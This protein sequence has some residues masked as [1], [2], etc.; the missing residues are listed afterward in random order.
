MILSP[1]L[2]QTCS[3]DGNPSNRGLSFRYAQG[4]RAVFAVIG[5]FDGSAEVG[6]HQLD[7]VTDAQNRKSHSEYSRIDLRRIFAKDTGRA[8]RKDDPARSGRAD[9][10]R[11]EVER[12]NLGIHPALANAPG[13]HLGVLR[14]EIED[15]DLRTTKSCVA[16]HWKK[17]GLSHKPGK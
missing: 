5:K 16:T 14:A 6:C 10:L 12:Q 8:A 9:L 15:D 3:L 17:A 1:W 13:D 4:S 2:F 7:T 11:S